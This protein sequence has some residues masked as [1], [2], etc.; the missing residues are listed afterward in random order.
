MDEQN[1][2]AV[3]RSGHLAILKL[4]RPDAYNALNL[5][6]SDDLLHA[7]IE[8]DE[9][10]GVR[11]LLLSGE[12][13]AFCSGGDIRQMKEKANA[14]GRAGTFLKTL[15]TRL[16]AIV[17]TMARMHKPVITAVN[18]PAAG[19]GLSIAL[20]GDMVVTNQSASFTVAY[21][22]IGLAP[23]GSSTYHLPRLVGPET[24]LRAD[25]F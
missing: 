14:D 13:R 17:S 2:V 9:D 22:A 10:P 20:A 23:D 18:G 21:T 6:M 5:Q 24:C 1:V 4:N 12:G 25:R 11:A 7:L 15:T 3:E 16:H 19:A 8:C